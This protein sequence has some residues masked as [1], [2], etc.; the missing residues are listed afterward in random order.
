MPDIDL[1]RN[2]ILKYIDVKEKYEYLNCITRDLSTPALDHLHKLDKNRLEGPLFGKTF[3][4]KDNIHIKGFPTS[5]ASKI[6]DNYKSIYSSTAIKRIQK[7][8]G[9]IVAKT[10]LDEFAMGSSNEYSIYGPSKNPIN[11]EYVCGGSSGGSAAAVAAGMV[12]VALGSDTG[13]S[14]RQ[15]A[16]FCGI[17]GLKPTYGRIS[18][19]GLTAFAS[20]F[21]QIGIFSRELNDLISTFEVISGYDKNDITSSKVKSENF[22]FSLGNTKKLTIG[23]PKEYM[24]GSI[25]TEVKDVLL[26]MKSFLKKHKFTIK[27]IDLPLTNKSIPTYYILTTAEASS[28]L[29]RY[30]GVK[31]GIRKNGIDITEMYKKTRSFGFGKEVKR[32]IILGTFVLSSGYYDDYYNKAL[33]IRRLIKDDFNRAFKKVD[34][35]LTP[36]SPF[37]P[38]KIGEKKKNPIEMYLSDIYTVPMSLAGLPAMNIP[39]GINKLGLPIGLQLTANQFEENKIFS[40]SNFIEENFS[41]SN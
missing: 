11:P 29:S 36:T 1:L 30:D 2:K 24:Q 21:D 41:Y 3:A 9:I 10:N 6:L 15:P 28:N 12:D 14:V 18:R 37:P 34:L 20:S 32:R 26:N 23:I 33:K 35:I 19:Y 8:G 31:Y 39:S 5:C 38:F 17:F 16:S 4:I 25:N 22:I 40:L 27:E 7:S 13:G